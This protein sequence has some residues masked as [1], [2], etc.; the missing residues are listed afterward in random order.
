MNGRKIYFHS[1]NPKI[2]SIMNKMSIPCTHS[3]K[4]GP[5]ED[6]LKLIFKRFIC[7]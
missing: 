3:P 7:I 6:K 4:S 2:I 1:L 5:M